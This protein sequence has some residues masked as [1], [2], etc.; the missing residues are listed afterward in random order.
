L[1][2]SIIV[3]AFN[4]E[5]ILADSLASIRQAATAFDASGFGW[6]LIVCDN[7]STDRTSE[8]AAQAGAHVVFEPVNQIARARNAGAAVARGQWLVFVDAD[9]HPSPALFVD[10]AQEIASGRCLAG[11]STVAVDLE[12]AGARVVIH[13]WNLTSRLMRWAAGSVIFWET[14]AFR[15]IGGFNLRFY[16][17]E[18]IDLFRRLKRLARARGGTIRILSK[19]PLHTSARKAHLYSPREFLVFQLKTIL[20]AG[21]TLRSAE[22][23]ALWYDGRR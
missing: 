16:A 22:G 13:G 15:E 2:I 18:E 17:A 19:H 20:T 4:E 21:R 5:A 23:S 10:V 11:G 1:L 8:I 12:H 6:E 7:N 9:S 3:P 14:V